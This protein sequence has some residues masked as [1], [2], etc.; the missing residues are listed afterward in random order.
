MLK[1]KL[2][3]LVCCVFIGVLRTPLQA[4]AQNAVVEKRASK[5]PSQLVKIDSGTVEQ[6]SFDEDAI[7]TYKAQPE[8]KYDDVAPTN[9]S[10]WDRFWRWFWDLLTSGLSG[11][12]S[13]PILK[14][15]LIALGIGALVFIVF[16]LAGVDPK[17]LVQRSKAIKVSYEESFENIHEINFDEQ[18][19][20]ALAQHN[21]RLA[22]RLLYLNSLKHLSDQSLITWKA[23]KTNQT[24]VSELV[25]ENQRAEFT[26]LTRQFEYV[27]YGDFF[28]DGAA[29]EKINQ[30][31][32]Q[33]NQTV[34]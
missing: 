8:F 14:Y 30:S 6:R 29:F 19:A 10:L 25:D 26:Q 32:H 31:F 18:I 15:L 33:F 7:A 1:V 16:K 24:Y 12:T 5:I 2:V 23:E 4:I 3:F 17:L 20:A 13:G 21:Y 34:R 11:P 9:P 22:V 28:V 27:W